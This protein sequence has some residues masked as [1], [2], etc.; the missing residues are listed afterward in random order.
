M[1]KKSLFFLFLTTVLCFS[2][3]APSAQAGSRQ[4]D[5]WKGI[6]IGVGAAILGGAL[7]HQYRQHRRATPEVVYR[8]PPQRVRYH[9]PGHWETKRIWVPSETEKVWREG[10]YDR[11]GRWYPG[12]WEKKRLPGYWIEKKVWSAHNRW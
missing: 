7:I 12:Y 2:L 4:R 1:N 9:N 10:H 6:A 3:L 5:R 11:Y 8:H